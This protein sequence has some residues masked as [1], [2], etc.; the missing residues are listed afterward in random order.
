MT[1]HVSRQA[2]SA[3]PCLMSGRLV[4]AFLRRGRVGALRR[5][6]GGGLLGFALPRLSLRRPAGVC[7]RV[8]DRGGN[9]KALEVVLLEL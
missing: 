9:G 1:R 6:L 2:R 8:G 7:G 4:V 5:L 3:R